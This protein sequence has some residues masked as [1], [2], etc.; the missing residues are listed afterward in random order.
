MIALTLKFDGGL[1][2]Y[3]RGIQEEIDALKS[4]RTLFEAIMN[5]MEGD[6]GNLSTMSHKYK[7][8]PP[9]PI[10]EIWKSKGAKIGAS[11]QNSAYYNLWKKQNWEGYRTFSVPFGMTEQV[12][13]G[14]TLSALLNKDTQGAVRQADSRMMVY[15]VENE[16]TH[17]FQENSKRRVLDFYDEMLR[18]IDRITGAWL[19]YSAPK[20][21]I[22][23]D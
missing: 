4:F 21:E 14:Q 1:T 13:S 9:S 17:H 7:E 8:K 12:L 2:A 5:Y 19:R 16:Y 3:Q 10:V 20:L 15:G 11:W 18:M 6:G 22:E 23:E